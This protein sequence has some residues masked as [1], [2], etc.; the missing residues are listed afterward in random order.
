MDTVHFM[1]NSWKTLT[2]EIVYKGKWLA[3]NHDTVMLPTGVVGE[4][5]Y[6]TKQDAVLVMVKDATHFYMVKQYRYP[7][8]KELIEFIQGG[9]QGNE[10]PEEIA[11]RETKEELGF[12]IHN[13]QCLGRIDVS[14][15]S[16]SQGMFIYYTDTFEVSNQK[17]DT[18][19]HGLE[20][21]K[22]TQ[23]ELEILI[24]KGDIT[25]GPS[26]AAYCLYLQKIG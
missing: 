23:T 20:V 22:I 2:T 8:R 5:D 3:L 19:E 13:L 14:K 7:V 24:Q 12:I 26:L 17:L 18:T 16:S 21:I 15:G 25:D 10:D 9:S 11:K 1:N 6:I 4:Y